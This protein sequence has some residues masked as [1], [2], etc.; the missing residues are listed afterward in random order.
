[1][2]T[3]FDNKRAAYVLKSQLFVFYNSNF[4]SILD[5]YHRTIRTSY[6]YVFKK[7]FLL[8]FISRNVDS[9]Y[10]Y[11][12]SKCSICRLYW[13]RSTMSSRVVQIQK[14]KTY[15][16]RQY[17]FITV[18]NFVDQRL[19]LQRPFRF[20]SRQKIWRFSLHTIVSV[21]YNT[22]YRID[23]FSDWNLTA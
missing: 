8:K 7:K 2:G 17:V 23:T 19:F 14:S 13:K 4:H 6:R 12:I 21:V 15:E 20:N 22:V 16:N 10:D 11:S 5:F 18:D 1:M 3:R 9:L